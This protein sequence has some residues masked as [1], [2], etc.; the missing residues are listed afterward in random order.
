MKKLKIL[1]LF[2]GR[3]EERGVSVKSAREVARC[4]DKEKYEPIYLYGEKDGAWRAVDGPWATDAPGRRALIAAGEGLLMEDAAGRLCPAAVDAA[5]IV[6][7]GRWGED[8]AAQGL[9]EL[10]RI[11]YAGCGVTAGALGMD[12]ALSYAVAREAG[13]RVPRHRVLY[14]G[15]TAQRLDI[16]YPRFVK[17]ARSGS[18]FGVSRVNAPEQMEAALRAA[19]AYD[20]KVLVEEAVEGMEIGCALLGGAQS[21]F[22]GALDMITLSGGFFRIHQEKNPE[23]GSENARVVAPAPISARQRENI[24]QAAVTVYRALGCEGLA[25]VDMFLTPRGEAVLNEVN[26]MPGLTSYSRYPRMMAAA[27]MDM[28]AVVD[29]LIQSALTRRGGAR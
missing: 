12:K 8:G 23:Q 19:R 15:E 2:G 3:S 29:R 14:E 1:V 21:P 28:A 24:E 27:G 26:T 16:G 11:P 4:L 13:V 22:V 7:H 10:A 17:P 25:R 18:S 20:G 9:M 6:L 5:L